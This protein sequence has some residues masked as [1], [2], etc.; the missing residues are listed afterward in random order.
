MWTDLLSKAVHCGTALSLLVPVR[1]SQTADPLENLKKQK[2]KQTSIQISIP[3]LRFCK[4]N[5][6]PKIQS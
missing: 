1:P 3:E 4:H 6:L 5:R 2:M